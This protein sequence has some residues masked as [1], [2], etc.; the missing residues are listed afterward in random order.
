MLFKKKKED[1]RPTGTQQIISEPINMDVQ[2]NEQMILTWFKKQQ[3]Y[4][5]TFAREQ[6]AVQEDGQHGIR[7]EHIQGE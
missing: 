5:Y 7:N 1:F 4:K 2:L 3:N 6:K